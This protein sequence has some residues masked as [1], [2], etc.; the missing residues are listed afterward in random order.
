MKLVSLLIFHALVFTA[1]VWQPDFEKAKA[2]A[3][4]EH[5]LI[6]LNFSGSDWCMPCMRM[7]SEIFDSEAFLKYA[8]AEL[9]LVNADFPRLKKNRPG[10]EIIKQNE[11]LAARYNR[12]GKFPFTVLLTPEGKLVKSWDGFPG[13]SAIEFV[14]EIKA[15]AH[16]GN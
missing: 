4:A 6:I 11:A 13:K 16:A 1:A 3:A 8:D 14:D 2:Q 5:K 12:E 15:V 7:R 10:K 9:V